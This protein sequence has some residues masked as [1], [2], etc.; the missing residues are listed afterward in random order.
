MAGVDTD[1][2]DARLA[3]ARLARRE[4]ELER[5]VTA[6]HGMVARRQLTALDIDWDAVEAHV[7]A[8]RWVART[9]RVI[10]TFTGVPTIEQRRWLG[11][12][13]AGP[14]S[15]LGGLT[16]GSRH[17]LVGW[18]R[19]EVTVLVDDELSFEPVDGIRFFRSRRPF[20]LLVSPKPGIPSAALE[21][22]VA[23]WAAYDA[24]TARVATGALAAVVQQRL[25]TATRMLETVES[26]RPLR[27]ARLFRSALADIGHGAHSSAELDVGRMCTLFRMPR[28]SRQTPRRDRTGHSR[29]TDCEWDL[30][31]GAVVVLEVEGPAH[32]ETE[33]QGRDARRQRRITSLQRIVLRCTSRELRDEPAEVALDLVALGVPG[34]LPGSAA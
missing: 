29:W 18:E 34:Q 1:G 32:L 5:L 4:R 9:P 6:Q 33:Q 10:S 31:G 21:P 2:P 12:L 16:A 28:P 25:T 27:R 11:V 22:A 8:R 13:H 23:L 19:D 17:G 14:R 30:P 3:P 20:S 24:P 15:I 26:L 7:V